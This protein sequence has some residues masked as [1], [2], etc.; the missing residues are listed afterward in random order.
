MPNFDRTGPIGEGPYTGRG[1]G[2]GRR[3][4]AR[5]RALNGKGL[6]GSKDCT[7]PKCGHKEA[8]VR[9]VPCSE[10]LCPKCQ[11]PMKGAF[12]L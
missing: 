9:G 11:T 1:M 10:Y 8:H 3:I 6:G 12:C 5:P 4:A 2:R 7:C